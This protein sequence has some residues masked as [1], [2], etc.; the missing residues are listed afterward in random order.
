MSTFQLLAITHHGTM[1]IHVQF[2]VWTDVEIFVRLLSLGPRTQL[3]KLGG[4]VFGMLMRWLVPGDPK[5]ASGWVLVARKTCVGLE[6]ELS[7]PALTQVWGTRG[8]RLSV[9]CN[10][11]D[12]ASVM[13]QCFLRELPP[14]E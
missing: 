1:D 8:R 4:S 14:A 2:F 10:L 9:T 13:K 5:R 12:P 3:L 11:I 6:L 7:A